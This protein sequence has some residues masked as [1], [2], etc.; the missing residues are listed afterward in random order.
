MAKE[1]GNNFS[2][3]P[4]KRKLNSAALAAEIMDG[5]ARAR[6]QAPALRKLA[7]ERFLLSKKM[8]GLLKI[9]N[10]SNSFKNISGGGT[11]SH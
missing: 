9:I 7:L 2:G 6:E 3:R 11:I 5:Y 10:N 4:E 1:A 8:D